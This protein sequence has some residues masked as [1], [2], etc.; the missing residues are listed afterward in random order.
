MA[1]EKATTKAAKKSEP[2][3]KYYHVDEFLA[4]K[5]M[6]EDIVF[7]FKTFLQHQGAVY[8]RELKDFEES[9]KE[10]YNRKI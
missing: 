3:V 5:G 8:Q 9:L 7:A 4:G 10:F 6:D 2:K 1:E